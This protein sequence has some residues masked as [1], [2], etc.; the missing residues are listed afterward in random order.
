MGTKIDDRTK[1]ADALRYYLNNTSVLTYVLVGKTRNRSSN[2]LPMC[3]RFTILSSSL[4]AEQKQGVPSVI[5]S[6]ITEKVANLLGYRVVK[7]RLLV[8]GGE[9]FKSA[10]LHQVLCSFYPHLTLRQSLEFS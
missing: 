1:V 8:S 7:G 2:L 3:Y 10:H 9:D 5:V 4:T 6:D